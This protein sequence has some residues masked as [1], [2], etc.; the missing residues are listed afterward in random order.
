MDDGEY[1]GCFLHYPREVA[2]ARYP[3]GLPAGG[4]P[5]FHERAL[6]SSWI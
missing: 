2:H 3:G 6:E 1:N 5:M 4:T